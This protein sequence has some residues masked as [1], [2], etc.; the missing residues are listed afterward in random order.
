MRPILIN[1]APSRPANATVTTSINKRLSIRAGLGRLHLAFAVANCVLNW[2]FSAATVGS[3]DGLPARPAIWWKMLFLF[4][5][6]FCTTPTNWDLRQKA[7]YFPARPFGDSLGNMLTKVNKAQRVS[8]ALDMA[9]PQ[10]HEWIWT[11]SFGM[12]RDLIKMMH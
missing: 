7:V 8:D 1:V 2:R 3:C 5:Y 12:K 4:N 11:I 6:F 10:H 9:T